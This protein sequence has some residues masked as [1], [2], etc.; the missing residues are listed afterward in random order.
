M[1]NTISNHIITFKNDELGSIRV[2]EIGKEP[3]FIATDIFKFL[4]YNITTISTSLKRIFHTPLRKTKIQGRSREL[5][6][7]NKEEYKLF[8]NHSQKPLSMKLDNW[9]TSY[10]LP[11]FYE[12][13]N[14]GKDCIEVTL[15]I[16]GT[17]SEINPEEPE[18]DN[19]DTLDTFT[20]LDNSTEPPSDTPATLTDTNLQE[21]MN[22]KF[23]TVRT[24]TIDNTLW[25]VGKDIATSLGYSNPSKAV[26]THVDPEDKQ[27]IMLSVPSQNGNLYDNQAKTKT[28]FINESGVYSLILRSKLPAAKEFKHWVTSEIL[29]SVRKN[30]AYLTS[31]ALENAINDP[32]FGTKLLTELKK[33]RE[34]RN[35]AEQTLIR[36][37]PLIDF[38]DHVSNM[39]DLITIDE[40]AKILADNNIKIG[41]TRL[42]R[43]L[44]ENKYL[45]DNYMPYQPAVQ[46]GYLK[47]RERLTSG[48]KYTVATFITGKGQMYF[49]KKLKTEYAVNNSYNHNNDSF[50]T[51]NELD[52]Y[53]HE[54]EYEYE[55]E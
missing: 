15:N 18:S 14:E 32:E 27:Y 4:G 10:V 40:F 28:T 51:L 6:I 42:F 5:I 26:I 12:I 50:N 37:Q 11:T 34:A 3:Y 7:I 21:F 41:R 16:P 48:D 13:I 23:G 31:N 25:F 33:E 22:E 47:V 20:D 8:S 1:S 39:D 49:Y 44:K 43:W 9:I 30:Q 46:R 19:T 29:P 52:E 38:A 36:N 24:I 17:V 53:K 54:H 45:K 2:L 55:H 35:A